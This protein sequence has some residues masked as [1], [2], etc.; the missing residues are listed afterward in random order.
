VDHL[1]MTPEDIEAKTGN[2][3]C[4]PSLLLFLSIPYTPAK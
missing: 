3:A 4:R 2:D 1:E